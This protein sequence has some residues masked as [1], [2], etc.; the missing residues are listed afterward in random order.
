MVLNKSPAMIARKSTARRDALGVRCANHDSE[1]DAGASWDYAGRVKVGAATRTRADVVRADRMRLDRALSQPEALI[2]AYEE[3]RGVRTD[4][5]GNVFLEAVIPDVPSFAVADSGVKTSGRMM[6]SQVD[7]D[8]ARSPL[9]GV[10]AAM[11]VTAAIEGDLCGAPGPDPRT[12]RTHTKNYPWRTFCRL[13]EDSRSGLRMVGSG[14][15]VGPR[16]VLTA[17]HNV[18]NDGYNI[19]TLVYPGGQFAENGVWEVDE[20]YFLKGWLDTEDPIYDYALLVL[21]EKGSYSPGCLSYGYHSSN[22]FFRN[23]YIWRM[24]FPAD[25]CGCYDGPEPGI[26]QA[27]WHKCGG[28]LYGNKFKIRYVKKYLFGG[29][30]INQSGE[31]GSPL[32]RYNGGNRVVYGVH[33]AGDAKFLLAKR[34]T[35]GSFN[36]LNR[37]IARHPHSYWGTECH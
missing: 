33:I 26:Y 16:H 36:A 23:D 31:S 27:P 6:T 7:G 12:I 8:D 3:S 21:V 28:R 19:P 15:F 20:V 11:Q 4:R 29:D 13:L 25:S 24:G 17:A 1:L 32:Y 22:S 9:P 14:V 10:L 2:A 37:W 34:L 5:R 18:R 35:E 30:T